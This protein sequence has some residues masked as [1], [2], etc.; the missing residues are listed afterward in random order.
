MHWRRPHGFAHTVYSL[1]L[2]PAFGMDANADGPV[3]AKLTMPVLL[4]WSED[5]TVIP[6]ETHQAYTYAEGVDVRRALPR[7]TTKRKSALLATLRRCR[8]LGARETSS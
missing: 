3:I 6:Y 1:P 7:L 5:D 4:G 2:A 8:L